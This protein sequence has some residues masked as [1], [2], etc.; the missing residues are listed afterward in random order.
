MIAQTIAQA[1]A[2]FDRAYLV[3]LLAQEGT[4]AGAARVA[5]V[6]RSTMYRL[7][8][9]AGIRVPNSLHVERS[10]KSRHPIGSVAESASPRAKCGPAP[11]RCR[12]ENLLE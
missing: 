12:L 8:E 2:Q 6:T 4:A 9:R 7:L 1:R 3:E 5:G 10:L 11:R